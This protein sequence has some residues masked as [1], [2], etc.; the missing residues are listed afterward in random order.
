M[1]QCK[2]RAMN[3]RSF[4]VLTTP[5]MSIPARTHREN[6]SRLILP[7]SACPAIHPTAANGAKDTDTASVSDVRSPCHTHMKIVKT[8][9]GRKITWRLARKRSGETSQPD[10]CARVVRT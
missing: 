5:T 10:L 3:K 2:C 9:M 8:C 6:K 1:L 4:D 7:A